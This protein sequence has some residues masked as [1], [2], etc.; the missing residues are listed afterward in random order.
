MLHE[1]VVREC[2]MSY[3]IRDSKINCVHN[4]FLFLSYCYTLATHTF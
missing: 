2:C 3:C 1:L 4:V